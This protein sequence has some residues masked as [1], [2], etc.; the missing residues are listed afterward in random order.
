M[1]WI[2]LINSRRDRQHA[3]AS[4]ACVSSIKT[5]CFCCGSQHCGGKTKGKPRGASVRWIQQKVWAEI[6]AVP[7]NECGVE[8]QLVC[9]YT[10]TCA[11]PARS[12]ALAVDEHIYIYI[13]KHILCGVTTTG[14]HAIAE[15]AFTF[16]IKC[17][18]ER[19]S[20]CNRARSNSL[21][22]CTRMWVFR[23]KSG[24]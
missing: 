2:T 3:P 12:N 23:K 7:W 6:C 17:D 18:T 20:V 22:L 5:S 21:H 9:E 15:R 8:Y 4:D 13:C 14:T 19:F 24:C 10:Y 1:L 16:R 11:I